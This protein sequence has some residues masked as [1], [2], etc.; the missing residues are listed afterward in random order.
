MGGAET[1]VNQREEKMSHTTTTGV[2]Q[3][4]FGVLM[5]ICQDTHG[6]G[7]DI[8]SEPSLL[9][10]EFQPNRVHSSE[11]KESNTKKRGADDMWKA[12]NNT[13]RLKKRVLSLPLRSKS[14][15]LM[16]GM[17]NTIIFCSTESR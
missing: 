9:S 7:V 10:I 3:I 12:P 16:Q 17:R 15:Q 2:N 4:Y 5:S 11:N 13:K 1:N 8:L 6:V 14:W